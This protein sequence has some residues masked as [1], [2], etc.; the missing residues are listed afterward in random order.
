MDIISRRNSIKGPKTRLAPASV[1]MGIGLGLFA[2]TFV[3]HIKKELWDQS[4]RS[5]LAW[6]G[7]L[8]LFYI[9]YSRRTSK[10]LS[11]Q[12][13]YIIHLYN[14][15]PEGIALLSVEPPYYFLQLN[16]EGLRLLRYPDTAGNDA[17][18]GQTLKDFIHPEDYELICAAVENT[19][20]KDRKNVYENRLRRVD[21]SFFWASGI[22]E[23]TLD[24]NGNPVLIAA[25]HDI[26]E[27][28][29]STQRAEKKKLQERLT[30]VRAISNAYPVI[31]NINLTT[32]ALNF[33]YVKPGLMM[34]LGRQKT[35]GELFEIMLKTVHPDNLEEFKAR[36]G[37]KN[38][39][40]SLGREK[41]EFFLEA[42]QM[43]ADGRYHWTSTQII[44]VDNP[45]SEEKLA[46][47]I[48]RRIDEQRYE[49]QQRRLALES[50]LENARAANKAK[51]QFLSNMSHD[52]RTPMNAI[53][54]MNAIALAHLED[55]Q[56]VSDCLQKISLSSKHLLSLINDV[57]DMSKIESG[58]LTLREEAFHFAE[59]AADSVELVRAQ[60]DSKRLGLKVCIEP[61]K[62]EKVVGDPLR[63]Q[64]V[65]VNI[66]SN[67]VKYTQSGGKISIEVKQKAS[68]VKGY[69]SYLFRCSDN[70]IGMSPEF[71]E[72]LFL[73]FERAKD[74][75]NSKIIGT[76]LGMAITKNIV[77]LMNGDIRVESTVGKGSVFTVIIPLR[78][79]EPG[80]KE[81]MADSF[82]VP[83]DLNFNG[84]RIL[85]AEDNEI[86]RE[87]AVELISDMGIVIEEAFDGAEAVKKVSD[88]KEGY[89]H[90]VLMDIQM[91]VMD[92]YEA[93][94]AIRALN[95]EDVKVLPILA[96]TANA[97]EEDIQAACEAGMNAHLAKPI[98]MD[99]LGPALYRY[100]MS[101]E[102][103]F[104]MGK[105]T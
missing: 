97:F 58:K 20:K 92:G 88:S 3:R 66:L 63:L 42:K 86:N 68:V 72:T 9:W 105:E 28:K 41:N 35:Y 79:Q 38:L 46:I 89:Y 71:L 26:T 50:A 16:K 47:L 7:L 12:A 37:P 93:T 19:I 83:Q 33:V 90:M 67:A 56:K 70:G 104:S 53:V 51:S 60:A 61:L 1:C 57:L 76:G 73:P 34:N 78:L 39:I 87:I 91:P 22:I 5:I 27:Q 4:I 18:R 55:R 40:S 74:S 6:V 54:G 94:R 101:S 13:E 17:P 62:N 65:Y 95:R 64:Q 44:Y 75:T 45:Y 14:A 100:L 99:I 96:M 77:D 21:G 11:S 25:F 102:K 43:M 82:T 84:K 2:F 48:S 81:I 23:K 10:S 85:L 52:I 30:L 8:V 32:D 36:F 24:E 59:L 49:E 29:N 15:I 69:Q 80:E 98:D 31:I 103:N